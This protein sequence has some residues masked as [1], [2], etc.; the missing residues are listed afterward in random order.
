M[1]VRRMTFAFVGLL[2]LGSPVAVLYCSGDDPAAMACCQDDPEG[3]NRGGKSDDC[4]RTVPND[5]GALA[6]LVGSTR[7]PGPMPATALIP[8]SGS[9]SPELEVPVD[10]RPPAAQDRF[11]LDPSPPLLSPLRV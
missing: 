3:C 7:D 11:L 2:F 6:T 8:V 1:I 10:R 9:I 5:G 4:C